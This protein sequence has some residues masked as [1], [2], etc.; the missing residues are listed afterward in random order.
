MIVGSPERSFS[1]KY[2]GIV[3]FYKA[4]ER[5]PIGIPIGIPIASAP[6]PLP[7]APGPFIIYHIFEN[8][9]EFITFFRFLEDIAE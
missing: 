1:P 6:R 8:S 9:L 4:F 5:F 3:R 7:A 2:Q